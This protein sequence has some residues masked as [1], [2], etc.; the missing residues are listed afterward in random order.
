M[1]CGVKKA[2]NIA[3]QGY[4]NTNNNKTIRPQR[5]TPQTKRKNLEGW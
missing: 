4:I 1:Y 2:K 3:T 5:S